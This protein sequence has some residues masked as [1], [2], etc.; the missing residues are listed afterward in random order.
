MKR[1]SSGLQSC[2]ELSLSSVLADNGREPPRERGHRALL[3]LLCEVRQG[4][5]PWRVVRLDDL[6]PEG[7][8]IAWYP[9]V[10]KDL[11]V[12]IRIPGIQLL[13][14]HIRWHTNDAIGCSFNEPLHVAV[15]EHLVKKAS[16]TF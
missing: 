12:R 9:N 14:A 4:T 3:T 6:S 2:T 13:T 16:P 15:F 10:S 11:P 1:F 8:R 7:F 5:R